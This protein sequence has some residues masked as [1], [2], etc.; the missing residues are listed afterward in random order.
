MKAN[1]DYVRPKEDKAIVEIMKD[2]V[3]KI[4]QKNI[5]G[6]AFKRNSKSTR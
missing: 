3:S 2:P 6:I 4:E 1:I 5:D